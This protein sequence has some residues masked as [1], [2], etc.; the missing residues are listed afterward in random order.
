MVPSGICEGFVEASGN[1]A[2][3]KPAQPT[4]PR[5]E[6]TQRERESFR[7]Y[8]ESS[9]DGTDRSAEM[10]KCPSA[11]RSQSPAYNSRI[12]QRWKEA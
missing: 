9:K 6:K 8:I 2:P 1:E 10:G 5:S 4:S 12:R 3:L 7:E 11:V